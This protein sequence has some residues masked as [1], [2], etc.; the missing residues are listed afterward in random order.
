MVSLAWGE[1]FDLALPAHPE[2]VAA[3]GA[4]EEEAA[5][6]AAVV[7]RGVA[8]FSGELEQGGVVVGG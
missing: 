7:W 1:A 8:F 2:V 4:A 6:G 5:L 3:V